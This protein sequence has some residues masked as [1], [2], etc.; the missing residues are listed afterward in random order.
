MNQSLVIL[1]YE[2]VT[3][4]RV[5]HLMS[6]SIWYYINYPHDLPY[7]QSK[8]SVSSSHNSSNNIQLFWTTCHKLN[9]NSEQWKSAAPA[10]NFQNMERVILGL[11]SLS[12]TYNIHKT[13]TQHLFFLVEYFLNY[14]D[15][16]AISRQ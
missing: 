14:S 10:T 16:V 13:Y 15:S 9:L 3:D 6:A 2:N 8:A 11:L 5:S 12:T 4:V 7:S 1:T